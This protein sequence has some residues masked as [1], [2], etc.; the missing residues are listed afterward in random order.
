MR[1]RLTPRSYGITTRPR[2]CGTAHYAQALARTV[3]SEIGAEVHVVEGAGLVDAGLH[4]MHAVGQAARHAPRYIELLYKGTGGLR[5]HVSS[6]FHLPRAQP[7]V[8]P[9]AGVVRRFKRH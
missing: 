1:A 8:H 6:S 2:P 5:S 3:A 4:L 7:A 9:T